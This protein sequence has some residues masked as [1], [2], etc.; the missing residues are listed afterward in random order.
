MVVRNDNPCFI[1]MS[2]CLSTTNPSKQFQ[3]S[4]FFNLHTTFSSIQHLLIV[5]FSHFSFSWVSFKFSMCASVVHTSNVSDCQSFL[6][7]SI[8]W[9][10]LLSVNVVKQ[11]VLQQF[12]NFA[13]KCLRSSLHGSN[14]RP[15]TNLCI[16][17]QECPT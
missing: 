17:L 14:S 3:S 2:H 13:F 16:L 6:G 9:Y 5:A 7:Y 4:L 15:Q 8:Q 10:L 1:I 12:I 11:V